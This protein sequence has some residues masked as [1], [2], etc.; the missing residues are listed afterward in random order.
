MIKVLIKPFLA[1]TGKNF[2][3]QDYI[4]SFR[5]SDI[6][7]DEEILDTALSEIFGLG[8]IEKYLSDKDVTD[9]FIQNKE[10]LIIKNGIKQYEGEVF[11]SMDDVNLIVDR[12]KLASEKPFDQ[13]V[14][15]LNTE[16][17]DG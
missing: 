15:F 11:E 1:Q 13:R 17:Y 5:Q 9:V 14:P 8:I 12:I 4:S 10:M 16:L 6:R 3:V 7:I 2:S